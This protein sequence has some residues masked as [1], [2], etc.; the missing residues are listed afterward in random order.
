MRRNSI[1]PEVEE[2]KSCVDQAEIRYSMSGI[3]DEAAEQLLKRAQAIVSD[4]IPEV[5]KL[6]LETMRKKM[7]MIRGL[8]LQI[9]LDANG[10]RQEL[11]E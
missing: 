11:K 3:E 9:M 7:E 8:K 2:F 4:K 6:R 5:I 10:I 1:I